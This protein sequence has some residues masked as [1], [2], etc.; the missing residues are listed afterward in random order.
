MHDTRLREWEAGDISSAQRKQR[1]WGGANISTKYTV[2][3][4]SPR[5]VIEFLQWG[6]TSWR[7]FNLPNKDHQLGNQVFKSMSLWSVFSV[8][9]HRGLLLS[10]H[11]ALVLLSWFLKVGHDHSHLYVEQQWSQE[12]RPVDI[13]L[14]E[15]KMFLR[16]MEI[17]QRP[18]STSKLCKWY[19]PL[20]QW[21]F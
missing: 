3:P 12:D 5:L 7:F 4:G 11:K 10:R 2:K 14:W 17:F 19:K 6:C 9:L 15:E 21:A 1:G 16:L 20:W 18:L 13:P 8:N